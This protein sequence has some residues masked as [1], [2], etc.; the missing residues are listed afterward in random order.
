MAQ[1]LCRSSGMPIHPNASDAVVRAWRKATAMFCR[2]ASHRDV[3]HEWFLTA[4]NAV[5][6]PF[7]VQHVLW[8][9]EQCFF[10]SQGSAIHAA[11]LSVKRENTADTDY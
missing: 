7:C 2:W 4:N 8:F 10:V 1:H 3:I 9:F 11:F 5:Q 6:A